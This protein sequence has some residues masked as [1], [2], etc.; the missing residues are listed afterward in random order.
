MLDKIIRVR[1]VRKTQAM[2]ELARINA[3]VASES[4]KLNHLNEFCESYTIKNQLM[5]VSVSSTQLEN[6]NQFVGTLIKAR[7]TQ[8]VRVKDFE[9]VLN[10]KRSEMYKLE[11]EL[12]RLDT[13]LESR[14]RAQ[15]AEKQTKQ[16]MLMQDSFNSVKYYD[17]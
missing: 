6:H 10:S 4:G 13:R 15:R 17:R 9:K 16:D 12:S 2:A 7:A 1:Q 5:N 8:E 14:K 11:V 3:F